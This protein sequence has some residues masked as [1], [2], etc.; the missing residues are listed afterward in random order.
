M[1]FTKAVIVGKGP[2]AQYICKADFPGHYTVAV[3]QACI[4]IDDVDYLCMNDY[5]SLQGLTKND[6]MK[7]KN[8]VI[9]EWPHFDCRPKI[10]HV[11]HQTI[12]DEVVRICDSEHTPNAIVFDLYTSPNRNDNLISIDRI[13]S[14]T[15]TAISFLAK[16]KNVIDITTFG[17][18]IPNKIGHHIDVL[19]FTKN[20]HQ[21]NIHRLNR[22]I[23]SVKNLID[24][25]NLK[26]KYN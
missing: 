16:H 8:L 5:E 3:N 17:V 6:L 11:S 2:T 12:I 25:Y 9:P 20:R 15:E 22:D 26:I 24:K 14:S 4:F 21:S 13:V 7:V 18:N 10:P 1:S 23:K 19:E